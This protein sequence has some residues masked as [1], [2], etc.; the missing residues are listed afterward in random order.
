MA[1]GSLVFRP[2]A[3]HLNFAGGHL[4]SIFLLGKESKAAT[5]WMASAHGC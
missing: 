4:N 1:S 5:D 3:V 2:R